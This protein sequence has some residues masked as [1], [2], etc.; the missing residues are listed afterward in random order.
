[1]QINFLMRPLE[2]IDLLTDIDTIMYPMIWFETTTEL[3]DDL[4]GQLKFLTVAPSLG[5]IIGGC[6]TGAG[7]VLAAVGAYLV[8]FRSKNTFV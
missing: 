7:A 2:Y 3:T 4:V 8:F 1:M 6:I 5:N